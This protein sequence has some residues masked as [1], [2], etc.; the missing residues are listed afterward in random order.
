MLIPE[1]FRDRHPDLR[2]KFFSEEYIRRMEDVLALYEKPPSEEEVVCIL[3]AQ[4][5]TSQHELM[6]AGSYDN[7]KNENPGLSAARFNPRRIVFK[8]SHRTVGCSPLCLRSRS[9]ASDV[10]AI[11]FLL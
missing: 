10:V 6:S 1:H 7:K 4:T 3:L 5:S 11:R 9:L 8:K 2:V